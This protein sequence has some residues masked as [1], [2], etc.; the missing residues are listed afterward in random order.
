MNF[1]GAQQEGFGRYQ[2]HDP[3]GRSALE[4]LIGTWPDREA[5]GPI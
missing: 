1:N 2:A 3:Q 4:C 5:S